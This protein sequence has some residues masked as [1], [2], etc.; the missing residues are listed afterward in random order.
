[1]KSKL[2]IILIAFFFVSCKTYIAN[3]YFEKNGIYD[4]KVKL[5]KLT[6]ENDIVLVPM[7]HLG[8]KSFYDDVKNKVDSLVNNNHIVFYEMIMTDNSKSKD[9]SQ[10]KLIDTTMVLKFRKAFGLSGMSKNG[11][12]N[13]KD[14]FNEKGIKIKKELI[15]QPK[16]SNLGLICN[17]CD[18]VDATMDELIN[19]YEN[20][21]G[22]IILEEYDLKTPFYENYDKKNCKI[23][24]DKKMFNEFVVNYRNHK[25]INQINQNI[26]KKIAIVYGKN[27]FIGIKDSL[28]KMGYK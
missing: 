14:Y 13:Y 21:Y 19:A 8:T 1:M 7:H 25:I 26:H 15:P 18:N 17:S 6:G 10:Q 20:K 28:H 11:S 2:I 24:I 16:L 27:H 12:S 4:E 22:K 5:E 9:T 3:S 23:K